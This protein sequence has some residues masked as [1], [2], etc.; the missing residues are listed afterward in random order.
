MKVLTYPNRLAGGQ[1]LL[2]YLKTLG[3]QYTDDIN[4][5]GVTHVHHYNFSNK[6]VLPESLIPFK[7][8][9]IKIINEHLEN[10][11]KDHIDDVFT[12]VFG[13]SLRLDPTT[14]RGMCGVKSTQ[15]AIHFM[16]LIECPIKAYQVD[17][18][19]RY[20]KSGEP[21]YRMYVKFID[22][23]ISKDRIRDWR[24]VVMGNKPVYLFEKHIESDCL[25]HVAKDKYFKVFGYED[26]ESKF[27]A[28]EVDNIKA[29]ILR[30]NIDFGEIDIL[31]DNSTG[32]IYII[33]INDVP[34]SAI[35]NHADNSDEI[36]NYLSSKYKECYL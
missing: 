1:R 28:E 30:A 18:E 22:T 35:W 4:A 24:I 10:I 15:N 6:R 21:H 31:R 32:L 34:A 5:K 25:T 7:D 26:W 23:R 8:K 2:H 16:K 33:D 17:N 36:L 11:K 19:P 27:S 14:H 12:K 9:G 3:V 20:S 13:Y 29:F